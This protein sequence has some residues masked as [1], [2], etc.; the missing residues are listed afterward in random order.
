LPTYPVSS[1]YWTEVTTTP[2]GGHWVPYDYTVI[3]IDFTHKIVGA[4][5]IYVKTTAPIYGYDYSGARFSIDDGL[6]FD[7]TQPN[8]KLN[9]MLDLRTSLPGLT[10]DVDVFL[11]D[12][13][14]NVRRKSFSQAVNNTF[15]QVTF[16]VGADH[17]WTNVTAN[18]DWTKIKHVVVQCK[19][20]R[21]LQ[22][23]ALFGEWNIDELYFS[24]DLPPTSKLTLSSSPSGKIGTYT[25]YTGSYPF[26]T[27][28]EVVRPVDTTATVQIDK[29]TFMYWDDDHQKTNPTRDFTYLAVDSELKAIYTPVLPP[30]LTISSL[31]Q[32][33]QSYTADQAVTMVNPSGVPQTV[34]VPNGWRVP[35][36]GIWSFTYLNSADRTFH[37]WKLPDNTASTA[38][39]VQWNIQADTHLEVHW[40]VTGGD[41]TI[42]IVGVAVAAILVGTVLFFVS[43]KKKQ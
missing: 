10:G 28:S 20:Y 38:K 3:E 15:V 22:P 41:N 16:D 11:Y 17:G 32:N 14:N 37:H 2:S 34:K 8:C 33:M 35:Q 26:T 42:L 19:L 40:N 27:T 25:D 6:E 39:T 29:E 30:L 21:P 36:K 43:R 9:F 12:Y 31:D 1:D 18:F 24:Y 5:S 7:G 13:L 4:T 23:L